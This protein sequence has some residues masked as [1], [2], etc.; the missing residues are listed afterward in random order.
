M[1]IVVIK[2]GG[3]QHVV[4]SGKTITIEKIS[5]QPGDRV[6]FDTL[7]HADGDT[8]QI[9]MPALDAKTTATIAS[10]GRGDKV[11]VVKYKAKT[12]YRRRVGHRQPFTKITVAS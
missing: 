12:R 1:S 2:A 8:V 4:E 3:K 9:G 11:L 5:G 7:L 10:H 6:S